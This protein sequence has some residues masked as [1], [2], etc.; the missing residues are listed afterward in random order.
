MVANHCLDNVVIGGYNRTNEYDIEKDKN[1][2]KKV[3]KKYH[4][5]ILGKRLKPYFEGNKL[6]FDFK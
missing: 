1:L 2:R 4:P 6:I 3:L 5:K